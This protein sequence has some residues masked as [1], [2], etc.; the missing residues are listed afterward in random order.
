MGIQVYTDNKKPQ[1]LLK[2]IADNE[3][4]IIEHVEELKKYGYEIVDFPPIE[5]FRQMY[6]V[7]IQVTPPIASE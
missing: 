2:L 6:N 7:N 5:F 3:Q 1:Q 4:Q